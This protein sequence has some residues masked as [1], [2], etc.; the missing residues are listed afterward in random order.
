MEE[1]PFWV[2]LM[3]FLE[4]HGSLSGKGCRIKQ[5]ELARQ[6]GAPS[7][8]VHDYLH[9]M[10]ELQVI[11]VR[12]TTVDGSFGSP[13]GANIYH[14]IITVKKWEEHY[15]PAV[16]ANRRDRLNKHRTI[17]NRNLVREQ[18][19]RRLMAKAEE[20]GLSVAAAEKV[21]T[22]RPARAATQVVEREP[23]F[24]PGELGELVARF[25]S[26]DGDLDGW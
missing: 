9:Q 7:R 1:Q 8:R 13:R 4:E 3:R 12:R 18:Q 11:S 25:A 23:T 17:L 5:D 2:T 6:V 22:P 15:G 20:L 19:R 16:I 24:A 26:D 10:E 14:S 21:V